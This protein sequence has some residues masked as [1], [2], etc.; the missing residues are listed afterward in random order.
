MMTVRDHLKR[1]SNTRKQSF[2]GV[3]SGGYKDYVEWQNLFDSGDNRILRGALVHVL[4]RYELQNTRKQS[5]CGVFSDGS[6]DYVER[7]RSNG[8]GGNKILKGTLEH[9][10]LQC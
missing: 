1:N 4:P 2:C 5:F 7:Q 9:M 8:S 3:F 10:L 6:I